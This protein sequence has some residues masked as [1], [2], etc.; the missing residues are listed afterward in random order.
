VASRSIVKTSRARRISDMMT[1]KEMSELTGVSARTLRYYDEIGLFKPTGKSEAGYRLYDDKALE[2][3]Q[4]ILYFR[5]LDIP[6]KT[7]KEIIE[8]PTL[9]R[10]KILQLQKEMLITEKNRLERLII[11]IDNE[12]KGVET[13][14]FTVFSRNDTEELFHAM[15]EHM[16]E[17][18]RDIAIAEFGSVEKW[19]EHYIEAVSSQKV[20]E[21]YA[22]MVEW[23]GGKDE[24]IS[25]VKNPVSKEI[26]QSYQNRIDHILEKLAS[27]QDSDINSFEVR[28]LIAEYGFIV[29]QLLQL[30]EEKD[31]MLAQSKFFKQEPAKE[32]LNNQYGENFNLFLSEAI[33]AFYN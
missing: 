7:I 28:E 20:Q 6:L 12:L 19:R 23:Y 4:Q 31:I 27:K 10:N 33:Q 21:Q 13:M 1:I 25:T 22:K 32:K 26:A 24:Y 5:E 17:N 11:S 29:K 8:N 14:D 3:L 15:Y 9:D 2:I 16:P 30:K 18:I